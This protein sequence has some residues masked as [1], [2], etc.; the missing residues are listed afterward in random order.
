[1]KTILILNLIVIL[2]YYTCQKQFEPINEKVELTYG[3]T[4]IFDDPGLMLRFDSVADSRCPTDVVCVWEGNAAVSFTFKS[5]NNESLFVLNTH[6]GFRTDTL[7]NGYRIKLVDLKPLPRHDPPNNP[8]DYRAEV[9]I[10][11]N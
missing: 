6:T 3:Q 2:S 5:G 9:L 11:N 4:K 7:I 8:D 10:T 1:M